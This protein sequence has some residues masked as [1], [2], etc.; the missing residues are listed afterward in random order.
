MRTKLLTVLLLTFLSV[1]LFAQ[2]NVSTN[3]RRDGIWDNEKAEWT[4]FP[5]NEEEI[6][7]FEFNKDFTMFKH[8]TTSIT[9]AYIIKSQTYDEENETYEFDVVSD[10]GNKYYLTLDMKNENI[11]FLYEREGDIFLV[12]HSIKRMWLDEED[13]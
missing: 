12:N 7:F 13:E 2:L 3:L 11:R 6:T 10:V 1:S 8:T 9:S 4:I 5:G